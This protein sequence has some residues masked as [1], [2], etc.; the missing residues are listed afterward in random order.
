MAITLN[1]TCQDAACNAVVDRIDSGGGAGFI[2]FQHTAQN[3]TFNTLFTGLNYLAELLGRTALQEEVLVVVLSEFTRTPKLNADD[4]KDHWPVASAMLFG[5]G[6][7]GG[8]TIG[9]TNT[10]LGADPV[11]LSTG[12]YDSDGVVPDYGNLIAGILESTGVAAADYLPDSA[13]YTALFGG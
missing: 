2:E 13:P 12:R 1:T 3:D 8:R 7:Q 10:T 5:A 11:S 9:Q 4:G 6:V